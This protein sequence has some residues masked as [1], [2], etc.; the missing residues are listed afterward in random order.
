M[1]LY[2]LLKAT[3]LPSVCS[4]FIAASTA[5][6]MQSNQDLK[7]REQAGQQQSQQETNRVGQDSSGSGDVRLPDCLRDLTLTSQ[8]Q[9]KIK[10][11]V[12]QS[13]EEMAATW[14]MFSRAFM[15][16]VQ[17]EAL[18]SAAIED[19]L[20]DSQRTQV[21]DLRRKTMQQHRVTLERN[22]N[23]Q[24][25]RASGGTSLN[26]NGAIGERGNEQPQAQQRQITEEA[27]AA[28][29]DLTV[30]GVALTNEQ[31]AAADQ[32]QERYMTDLRRQ[33]RDIASLHV[34]LVCLEA[35]KLEEIELLLTPDQLQQLREIRKNAPIVPDNQRGR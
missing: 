3:L 10:E 24:L 35:K 15:A 32:M 9:G 30:F 16:S 20:S 7:Q 34:Q 22:E 25:Q 26:P 14:Q 29:D 21:R 2:K 28:Q 13:N 33:N 23:W 17:T 6:A 12:R 11:I 8:Q 1:S 27:Q 31:I 5:N 4:V 18:L 19:H